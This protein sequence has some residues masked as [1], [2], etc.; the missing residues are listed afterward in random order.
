MNWII[1]VILFPINLSIFGAI[2][3]VIGSLVGAKSQRDTNAANAALS[4]ENMDWMTGENEKQRAFN[5]MQ[6]KNDRVV[7]SHEASLARD[8]SSMEAA[9]AR[10]FNL[11]SSNTQYQRSVNDMREAGL[12][13]MLLMSSAHP[14]A[15]SGPAAG[16]ANSIAGSRASAT[17]TGSPNLARMEN[18]LSS[19]GNA[20][21]AVTNA[22]RS[23]AET[24]N[25]KAQN[26]NIKAQTDNINADTN[27]KIASTGLKNVQSDHVTKETTHTSA[28]IEHVLQDI[29]RIQQ[30]IATSGTSAAKN[31]AITKLLTTQLPRALN[32]MEAESSWFKK[33]VSPYLPDILK[34]STIM[35]GLTR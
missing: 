17:S 24:D 28:K 15:A 6:A 4:R 9:K 16:S 35:R 32:E 1:R 22:L 3:S 18:P 5:A 11:E 29:S 27:E 34:S 8:F 14:A 10:A 25:I 7:Q 2:G 19:A 21:S 23:L 13:P 30:D 31:K 12:N 20:V 26:A 33:N